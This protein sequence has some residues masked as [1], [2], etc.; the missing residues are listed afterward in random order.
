MGEF[1]MH[2]VC[3]D[4]IAAREGEAAAQA[5]WEKNGG[6]GKYVNGMIAKPALMIVDGLVVNGHTEPT[7]RK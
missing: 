5:L 6:T 2:A 3:Y 7:R 4:Q 1:H